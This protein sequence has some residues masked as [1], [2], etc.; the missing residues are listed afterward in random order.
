MY[1]YL[2]HI[3]ENIGADDDMFVIAPF[4]YIVRLQN[5]GALRITKLNMH[6]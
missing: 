3:F 4:T 2:V 1:D 6:K 5:L